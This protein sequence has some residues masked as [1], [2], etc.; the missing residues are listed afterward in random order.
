MLKV[1]PEERVQDTGTIP[2]PQSREGFPLRPLRVFFAN[3][4]V[5]ALNRKVRKGFRRGRKERR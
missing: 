5:K 3:S 4:A 1:S 2:E